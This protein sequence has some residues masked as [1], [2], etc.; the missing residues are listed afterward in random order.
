MKIRP[1]V[2]SDAPT[3]AEFNLRLIRETETWTPDAATVKAGVLAL[4]NDSGKGLYFVAESPAGEVIG[5]LMITHEWSDWRNGNIWWIQSVYVHADFRGQGIFQALFADVEERARA[6]REV[7]RLRLYVEKHN[8]RARRAYLKLGME[9]TP[10]EVME[11][12]TQT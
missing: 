5:Q 11:F 2:L 12:N 4:L 6:A 10:Y 8:E 3:I 9:E 7:C 1:A